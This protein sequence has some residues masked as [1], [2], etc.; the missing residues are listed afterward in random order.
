MRKIVLVLFAV[1]AISAT[2]AQDAFNVQMEVYKNFVEVLR[3]AKC[4]YFVVY[5]FGD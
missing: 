5:S 1:L 2:Q 4:N 3:F